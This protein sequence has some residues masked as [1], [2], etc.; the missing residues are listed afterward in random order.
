MFL[1]PKK[2][3]QIPKPKPKHKKKTTTATATKKHTKNTRAFSEGMVMFNAL[4][5]VM[6]SQVY[7]YV[8]TQQNVHIK[9]VHFFVNQLYLNQAS[10]IKNK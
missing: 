1:P 8:Q 4:I 3:P 7:L 2:K 6:I 5:M 10:K 9:Y